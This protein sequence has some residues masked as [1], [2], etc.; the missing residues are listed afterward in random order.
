MQAAVPPACQ[1]V[2]HGLIFGGH[3]GY[4]AT[5]FLWTLSRRSE[6][7]SVLQIA[8]ETAGHNGVPS[9]YALAVIDAEG[10]HYDQAVQHAQQALEAAEAAQ[11]QGDKQAHTAPIVALLALLLS[12]RSV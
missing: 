2:H 6:A 11:Q 7:R 4:I 5:C 12:A 3:A 8:A 10:G 1:T 9:L